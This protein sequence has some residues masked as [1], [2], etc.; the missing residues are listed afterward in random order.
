MSH[1]SY[2]GFRSMSACA[3]VDV[4]PEDGA[5]AHMAVAVV[6]RRLSPGPLD[7]RVTA[8]APSGRSGGGGHSDQHES[9]C[10]ADGCNK[11]S[12]GDVLCQKIT[13][14]PARRAE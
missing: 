6:V 14:S 7:Q 3:V 4:P 5:V 10:N 11:D 13:P 12:S 2:P 9:A 1:A 8:W